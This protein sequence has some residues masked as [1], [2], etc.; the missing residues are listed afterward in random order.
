MSD[1]AY[2][3][4]LRYDDLGA[5]GEYLL[6]CKDRALRPRTIVLKHQR[7]VAMQA[8]VGCPLERMSEAHAKDWWR[9]LT[10]RN[11][12]SSTRAVYLSHA[13]SFYAW[14][15]REDIVTR[16]PTRKLMMP[17]RRLGTPRDLDPAAVIAVLGR[18]PRRTRLAMSLMLWGGLRCAE[19]AEVRG[20]DLITRGHGEDVLRVRGKGG[21]ER[22]VKL[23]AWLAAEVRD[24]GAGWVFPSDK[25]H[26]PVMPSTVGRWVSSSLRAADIDATAH[27]LRHTFA[28]GLYRVKPDVLLLQTALG[29]ATLATAQV[30]A[31]AVGLETSTVESLFDLTAP[32]PALDVGDQAAAEDE[33]AA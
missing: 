1:A 8:A 27:Q 30:Y 9:A 18:V 25:D 17:K 5:V 21:N 32:P 26:G 22:V 13:R 4:R 33:P 29:H 15:V 14:A 3:A 10:R 2:L 24:V 23:P 31:R 19:V 7:L 20:Q 16:D 28:T 6:D 12:K 11:V